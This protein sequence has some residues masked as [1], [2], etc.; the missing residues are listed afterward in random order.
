M[1]RGSPF[2]CMAI[3]P[4]PVDA[5]TRCSE[6]DTSLRMLAPASTA[7]AATSGLRVSTETR[8]CGASSRTTGTT[9]R[10]SSSTG[11]GSAPGRVLSPPTSTMSAPSATRSRPC[12]TA[13]SKSSHRPPSEKESGVTF[14]TPMTSGDTAAQRTGRPLALRDAQERSVVAV[15]EVQGLGAGGGAVAELAP[16]GRGHRERARLAHAPH[17]HAQVLGLDDD[18]HPPRLQA[19][20]DLVGDLGGEP[21]LDL[22][23]LGERVD[24]AG[25]LGQAGDAAVL[26]RDVRN[27]RFSNKWN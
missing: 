22:G 27:V 23:P 24:K 6:A 15:D 4:A 9:R 5:A 7:A 25:Q 18:Q 21:L 19:G 2:M 8:T 10:S 1:V 14:K 16:H 17:R 20:V 12:A 3:Q 26:V 11:T 13:A